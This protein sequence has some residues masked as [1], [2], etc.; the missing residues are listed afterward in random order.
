MSIII[1]CDIGGVIRNQI[2]NTPIEDSID[3]LKKLSET[4][5]IIF[6]SKC[7]EAYLTSSQEWLKSHGLD[8]FQTFYCPDY[9]DKI[10]I[11]SKENVSIMID[12]KIQVLKTFNNEIY[13]IWFCSDSKRIL[14]LKK[15]QPEIFE[16]INL[17][18]SWKE[19]AHLI[20][21]K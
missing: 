7:K 10:I 20:N 15:F 13:K 16:S 3:T 8:S 4:S 14:G 12:D 1:G 21:E 5:K 2:D 6:I 18:T 19:V 9:K 17:A 11:A